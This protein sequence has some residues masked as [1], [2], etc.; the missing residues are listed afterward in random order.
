MGL[1]RS[2][3]AALLGGVALALVAQQAAQAQ[4]V[5]ATN[6]TL[7]ERL[8]IGAGAPKVAINTPQ[9]VT[10]LDQADIDKEQADTTG[11]L[12]A[13][14][15]GVTVVGSQRQF[16]EAFNIRGIGTT[17]NSS[18]GSRVII[19]IDGAPKF[20][21]QYRMGSFFSDP[22]LYKQVEVL[23]GPA[24][25][26]LYGAG[27]I[28]G[29][30]NFTTKDASD[31]LRDGNSGALR[32][33]TS[34]DTNGLGTLTS[35]VL[36]QQVTDTF[37]I[38]AAGNWRRRENVELAK[39]GELAGSGFDTLSGLI[40][41]TGHFGD[42]NEQELSL[43]YQRWTSDAKDQ[44]YAQTGTSSL[45]GVT[46]RAVL[47]QT[48]VLHWEN[49]AT[50]NPWVDLKVNLSYSDTQNDQTNHRY[51]LGAPRTVIGPVNPAFP[52]NVT[53]DS[54]LL[55]TRYGYKTWQLTADNT[56]EW[57]GDGFENYLTTGF[58]AST[59]DRTVVRPGTAIALPAHPQG[60]ENKLGIFAQNEFI[61]AEK[62]TLIA[63]A[64]GD[65]HWVN[66][67]TGAANI[68]GSAF[69]PKL[70]AHY[71][72]TDNIGVFGS[73]AHT[74][75]LP[76]I[77]ELYS[78]AAASPGRSAPKSTS[79]GLLKEEANTIEAGFSLSGNDLLT[80]G[81]TAA[82]KTT[83]FYSDLTNLIASN[84]ARPF[85]G[86]TVPYYGNIGK[87]RIYGVEVEASYDAE[88]LYAS[89]AYGITVGDNLVNNTP[90]TTVPQNKLALTMGIRNVEYNL[91]MGARLTI[92]DQ[93]RY[94]V[95][96]GPFGADGPADAYATVDL[97]ASWKP[98]TGPLAG[99][100]LQLGI[101]NLFNAD[102][103][104]NLSIDRSTGRTFKISVAKQFD[105]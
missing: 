42:N 85:G 62:L 32:V 55:D 4:N 69:S 20:N 100:E 49:P 41:G 5:N 31:Y 29:V 95:A 15:P 16:G 51:A 6:I 91:D 28:G 93:G 92:A 37:E 52:Q 87:A 56:I 22:E 53:A 3:A 67:T 59:Q 18:D 103:R 46:D 61:W 19:N 1:V 8:V 17:E 94:I 84:T 88:L 35:A 38:L 23:R 30:I 99:T 89:L 76:T 98:E 66:S 11:A 33:K 81:D 101:D 71:E 7:L 105:W 73:I 26:T 50:D 75:R 12:F 36:A 14:V 44:A 57:I 58:A 83:A 74:E 72:L 47:D 27:A 48:A 90:L 10:V 97:F 21:E 63:G 43:S 9:A 80:S 70:A 79:L 86:A 24:S 64:R 34:L 25:S 82:L 96:S 60:T 39:G 45:F 102:Y 2:R 54:I 40:K 104:P 77:D 78:V 68:E 13:T 65:F